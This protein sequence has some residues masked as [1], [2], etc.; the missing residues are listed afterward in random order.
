MRLTTVPVMAAVLLAAVAALGADT[1]TKQN[2]DKISGQ[3]V[4]FMRH[5]SDSDKSW[6][7]ITAD[8]KAKTVVLEEIDAVVFGGS[9]IESKPSKQGK[10]EASADG[11]WWLSSS[12][13]RHNSGC[14][15]YKTSKGRA[16]GAN[17]GVPCKVCGG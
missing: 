5:P 7:V 17:D 15:Y 6:F 12:G 4:G 16:C 14:R 8:G 1:I 13:K 3:I 11:E 9:T 2:G 10:A